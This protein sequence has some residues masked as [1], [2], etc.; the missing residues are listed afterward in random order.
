[1]NY[2]TKNMKCAVQ[3]LE[4]L[5]ID[6][7]NVSIQDRL[8]RTLFSILGGGNFF[9]MRSLKLSRKYDK[10]GKF[11]EGKKKNHSYNTIRNVL[12]LEI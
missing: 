12:L 9:A 2:L 11:L 3:L 4:L 10:K 7:A 5:S 8:N 1:M 6:H